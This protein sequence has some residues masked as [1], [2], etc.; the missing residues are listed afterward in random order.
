MS[1]EVDALIERLLAARDLAFSPPLLDAQAIAVLGASGA[2]GTPHRALLER[3][4]GGY[5]FGGA[6][7][8]F[9]ACAAP[10]W[11]S[12]DGW[13][14]P[15]LWRDAY[16]ELTDGLILFAEDAFGDQL[17]YGGRGGE[18]VRFEAELGRV[19]PA[20][21]HF[22]AWLEGL[23]EAPEAVLPM[24][25]VDEQARLGKQAAPGSQLYAYPP[26]ATVEARDGVTVGV[27]D[28]VEAM[29]AR[30]ALARQIGHLPPGTQ[31]RVVIDD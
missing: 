17:G 13:N 23:L 2:P 25:W 6:L 5:F 15:A 22:V 3:A 18:V 29:R 11:H 1:R 19:E 26:L 16:G 30:G 31:V 14:A 7:H 4:N 10:A 21:P 8:L 27:V 9:G 28:A 12:L 24:R 20:A